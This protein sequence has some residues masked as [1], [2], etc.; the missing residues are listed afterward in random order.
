[1]VT[2]AFLAKEMRKPSGL[3][4]AAAARCIDILIETAQQKT[5]NRFCYL[6]IDCFNNYLYNV[7]TLSIFLDED[8]P[9]L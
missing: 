8:N 6:I 2:K 9:S 1:M 7:I 5:L 3:S 4:Y